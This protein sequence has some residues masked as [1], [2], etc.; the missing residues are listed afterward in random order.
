MDAFRR[1]IIGGSEASQ[2]LPRKVASLRSFDKGL[3][4]KGGWREET[5]Q[6][7]E[8]QASF[9]YPFSYAPLGKWGHIS[10]ELFGLFLGVCLSPTPSRQPLFETS[11]SHFDTEH[12]RAKVP[13]YNG[14]GPTPRRAWKSKAPPCPSFPWFFCFTKEK[15]QINQG[16]L[17][18]AEPTE[19]LEKPKK[20]HK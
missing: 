14:S 9:L 13:W 2:R 12:D 20:T 6:R 3:A 11:A 19:T 16:L 1:A 10:G 4:D 17:S 7:P 5:L 18:P 8:I 15:P